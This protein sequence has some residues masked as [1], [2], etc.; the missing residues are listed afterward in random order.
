MQISASDEKHPLDEWSM[1]GIFYFERFFAFL[2]HS[3]DEII[4]KGQ[5][6]IS[7]ITE[8]RISEFNRRDSQCSLKC[9]FWDENYYT[10]CENCIFHVTQ[11]KCGACLVF[12]WEQ[13][14]IRKTVLTIDLIPVLPIKGKNTN[15]LLKLVTKTLFDKRPPNWRKYLTKFINSDRILPES[16]QQQFDREG[17]EEKPIQVA[18]KLLNFGPDRNFIIRPFQQLGVTK[19]FG[20]NEALKAVYC[21]I[22]CMKELLGAE[23]ISSYFIKKVLLSKAMKEKMKGLT[24]DIFLALQ[25][26]DLREKFEKVIDYEK[27]DKDEIIIPIIKKMD[28]SEI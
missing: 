6:Q 15:E 16:F 19:E 27:W 23:K 28:C 9:P 10:H 25:H 22:K 7:L 13:K 1:D 14:D 2:L 24:N 17:C 5:D 20:E 8:N 11:T 4:D 21:Q 26:P 12:D 3:V 18:V